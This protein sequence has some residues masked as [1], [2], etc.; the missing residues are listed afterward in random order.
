M[1]S[2]DSTSGQFFQQAE[3]RMVNSGTHIPLAN[4]M[5]TPANY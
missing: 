2:L 5:N 1:P 4:Q 3:P